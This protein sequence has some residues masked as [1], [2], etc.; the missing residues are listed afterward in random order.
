MKYILSIFLVFSIMLTGCQQDQKVIEQKVSNNE[1][2]MKQQE[3]QIADQKNKIEE[4]NKEI[5]TLENQIKVSTASA[6]ISSTE[7]TAY[8]NLLSIFIEPNAVEDIN[9]LTNKI[10]HIDNFTELVQVVDSIEYLYKSDLKKEVNIRSTFDKSMKKDT[11]LLKLASYF[12]FSDDIS[13]P[14]FIS[15]DSFNSLLNKLH[16]SQQYALIEIDLKK[17]YIINNSIL[18]SNIYLLTDDTKN[19]LYVVLKSPNSFYY[20][21]IIISK[22]DIEAL[23]NKDIL[24]DGLNYYTSIKNN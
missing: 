13:Y 5:T 16:A 4:N 22:S 17:P 24:L 8:Q 10:L 14:T 20:E 11:Y 6:N 9:P 18:V 3:Q 15:N 23:M 2:I 21:S 19:L 7:I 12:I 1:K